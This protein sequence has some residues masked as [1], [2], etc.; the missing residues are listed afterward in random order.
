[1][2]EISPDHDARLSGKM[3]VD[4]GFDRIRERIPPSRLAL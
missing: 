3:G 1:M 4:L 2:A